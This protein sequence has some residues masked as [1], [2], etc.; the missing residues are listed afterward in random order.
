MAYAGTTVLH[1]INW[2]LHTGQHWAIAG[3]NG[4][5]KSTLLKLIRGEIWPAPIA[6]GARTYFLDGD[7]TP[8]PIGV[9]DHI[10]LVSAEQQTR[11]LRTEWALRVWQVVFTGLHNTDLIYSHATAAELTTVDAMLNQM[12]LGTLRDAAFRTLSQGQL[13]KVLIAR[14]LVRKPRI[15][16]CDEIGVGL[17]PL[18][19]AALMST[20]ES[21]AQAGTQIIL[22]S[23]RREEWIP[24]I[25]NE[26]HLHEGRV[27][28]SQAHALGG[29]SAPAQRARAPHPLGRNPAPRHVGSSDVP[30]IEIQNANVAVDEGRLVVLKQLNWS[31]LPGQHWFVSGPNGAGKTTL[32]KFLLGELSAHRDGH[33]ARFGECG[34]SVLEIKKQIGYVS[35][36]LQVRYGHNLPARDVI[37]TGFFASVGWMQPVSRAQKRRVNEVIALLGL[38]ALADRGLQNM[39]YGQARK[40]LI[41]RALVNAPRLLLLDEVFDGL[42]A[43]FRDDISQVF[44]EISA[45]TSVVLVSHYEGDCL[46][47][48]THRLVLADGKVLHSSEIADSATPPPTPPPRGGE[49]AIAK[50]KPSPLPPREGLGVGNPQPTPKVSHAEARP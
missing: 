23:H 12:G 6:G 38:E 19:R 32:L 31:I 11:Y 5:G 34:G 25:T 40:V 8:S 22:V 42:D 2:A 16:I 33:I 18:A 37:A 50:Q 3:P 21:V 35:P 30:L 49:N 29:C 44:A 39:S 17:D 41:A 20:I 48:M 9:G 27:V 10:A 7:A 14:A 47:M 36:E 24:S 43:G 46:P 13:R 15:L 26:L 28:G 1:K 45:V 4:S